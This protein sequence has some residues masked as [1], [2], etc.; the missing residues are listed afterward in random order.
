MEVKHV[1]AGVAN[2]GSNYSV[3]GPDSAKGSGKTLPMDRRDS[4]TADL[5]E[6]DA[7]FPGI[8]VEPE[9]AD[10]D[11]YPADPGDDEELPSACVVPTGEDFSYAETIGANHRPDTCFRVQVEGNAAAGTPKLSNYFGGYSVEVAAADSEVAWGKVEWEDE[12]FADL[13]CESMTFVAAD[14][15]DVCAMFEDEVDQALSGKWGGSKGTVGV[16][17]QAGAADTTTRAH[18]SKVAMWRVGPAKVKADRFKTLWFDDN[19]NGKIGKDGFSNGTQRP[20]PD[21]ADGALV[22]TDV[23]GAT[24]LTTANSLHDLYNDNGDPANI[25]KIWQ[26]V[27][28]EDDDPMYGDFGKVDL[29]SYTAASGDGMALCT[30]AETANGCNEAI[31]EE[32]EPDG[33]ADNYQGRKAE[34]CD[35]DDGGED[36]CDAEWSMDYDVTFAD[37]V[38]G[39]STTR[40]VTITCSWDAQGGIQANPPD[41]ASPDLAATENPGTRA[42]IS[43][44]A[45]C[46]ASGE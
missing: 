36:A 26:F 13:E 35:P 37:G 4:D 8:L 27:I 40:M 46:K 39:C 23:D 33:K 45:K 11:V 32:P 5:D 42:N 19:L 3:S 15:V 16:V 38:F 18:S 6:N 25:D 20:D 9:P 41:I 17:A 28:D 31:E 10:R 21:G 7:Y 22:A 29:F 12:P 30:N 2:S 44:F 34:A 43:N 24:A 1:F 14:Q